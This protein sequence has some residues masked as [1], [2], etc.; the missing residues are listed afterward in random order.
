MKNFVQADKVALAAQLVNGVKAYFVTFDSS[1][2]GTDTIEADNVSP[3]QLLDDSWALDDTVL[4][5]GLSGEPGYVEYYR[6][7]TG[8]IVEVIYLK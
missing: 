5:D 7:E 3:P 1:L 8:T 2:P 6:E 4:L